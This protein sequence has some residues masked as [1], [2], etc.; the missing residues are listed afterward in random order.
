MNYYQP[1]NRQSDKW[2]LLANNN[3]LNSQRWCETGVKTGEVVRC[4][5]SRSDLFKLISVGILFRST[6]FGREVLYSLLIPTNKENFE[7]FTI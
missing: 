3:Y 5:Y 7:V 4:L 1:R 2:A 6:E